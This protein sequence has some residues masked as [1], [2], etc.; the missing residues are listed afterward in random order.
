MKPHHFVLQNGLD[1]RLYTSEC[2]EPQANRLIKVIVDRARIRWGS[3]IKNCYLVEVKLQHE[4]AYLVYLWTSEKQLTTPGEVIFDLECNLVSE[5]N[6]VNFVVYHKTLYA[7]YEDMAAKI[8]SA[9]L[10][11][12]PVEINA[13]LQD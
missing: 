4:K 7:A 10:N 9:L 11:G 13:L 2:M 3:T 12:V 6:R 1:A 8:K 5:V